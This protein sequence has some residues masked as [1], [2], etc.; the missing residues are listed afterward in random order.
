[1]VKFEVT[2]KF[3]RTQKGVLTN[4]YNKMKE[5]SI[6]YGRP[7]PD[8][9]LKELHDRFLNDSTFLYIF[10]NWVKGNYQYYLKPS[11]DRIN[12]D[13]PYT[14]KNIQIMTW[15]DNRLKGDMENSKRRNIAIL[16]YDFMG[17]VIENFKSITETHEKTGVSKSAIIRSCR[18]K[19]ICANGYIFKYRKD[20][21]KNNN[22]EIIGT[23]W[24]NPE[25]EVGE[26]V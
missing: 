25:L 15:R 5:R 22:F 1:M 10:N 9:S 17:N 4:I 26:W 13:M 21:F 14:M 6:K 20:E 11:I 3:R 7:L 23:K 24:D 2:R 18:G 8:F 12:P 16:K 19:K